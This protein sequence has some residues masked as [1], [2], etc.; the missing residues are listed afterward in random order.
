MYIMDCVRGGQ[1]LDRAAYMLPAGFSALLQKEVM[2]IRH[3]VEMYLLTIHTIKVEQGRDHSLEL[4]EVG[5]LLPG[6]VSSPRGRHKDS[7]PAAGTRK[8]LAGLHVLV[9]STEKLFTE[10]WESVLDS[11]GESR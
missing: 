8:V 2:E 9:I 4:Q 11:L 7:A 6:R 10:D 5:C 3:N 1:L